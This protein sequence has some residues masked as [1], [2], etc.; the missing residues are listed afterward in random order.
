MNKLCF[1]IAS[2][3]H[4][5]PLCLTKQSSWTAAG[6]CLHDAVMNK[7]PYFLSVLVTFC[8]KSKRGCSGS[9]FGR[10]SRDLCFWYEETLSIR[11][12]PSD[13]T[14]DPQ[15]LPHESIRASF[16]NSPKGQTRTRALSL[17]M[18]LWTSNIISWRPLAFRMWLYFN[19]FKSYFWC[20]KR[21][22]TDWSFNPQLWKQRNR[23]GRVTVIYL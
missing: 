11:G 23:I 14:L 5:N 4:A 10:Q 20:A 13:W 3:C 15:D 12:T 17:I 9:R 18:M 7:L 6:R 19:C 2:V 22:I 16:V 8:S 21:I 1:L